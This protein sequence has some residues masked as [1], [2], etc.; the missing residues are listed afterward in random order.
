VL[1]RAGLG[2]SRQV[3]VKYMYDVHGVGVCRWDCVVVLKVLI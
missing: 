1:I 2:F 3:I